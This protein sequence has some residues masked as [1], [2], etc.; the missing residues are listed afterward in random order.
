MEW[1]IPCNIKFYDIIGA[2]EKF[3]RIDWKQSTNIEIGDVV[4]IY[5]GNPI[6][7]IKYKCIAKKVDLNNAEIDDSEF[8]VDGEVYEDYGRYMELE[9]VEAYG[10]TELSYN[11]LKQNGLNSVQGPSKVSNKLSDYIKSVTE[12]NDQEG[13]KLI[14][15]EKAGFLN[16]KAK[17][18]QKEIA[19]GLEEEKQLEKLRK[20]F[21]DHFI[22]KRIAE[23]KKE[24]YVVG[25]GRQDT[26][27]YRLENELR[28]LGDI[29]GST[30][31][32]FGLYY[33][34]K[35][36]DKENKYRVTEGKFG[37]DL[38]AAFERIKEQIENLIIAGANKNYAEIRKCLLS[39]MF[40][41]KI[42]STYFP[43]EYLS[44]FSDEHLTYFLNKL[45]VAFTDGED[46]LDKQLKLV[47]WKKDNSIAFNWSMYSFSRFLYNAFGKPKEAKSELKDKLNEYD[48][49]YPKEHVVNLG[50][51]IN[52]WIDLLKDSEVFFEK[53]VD[54][55][56]RIYTGEYHAKTCY[57]L[58]QEDGVSPS[59]YIK[60][61]VALARRIADKIE[62]GKIFRSNGKEMWWGIPFWGKYREDG[63]FEWK[64]RPKLAKAMQNIYPE[65]DYIENDE[66]AENEFL[67]TLRKQP[68]D[69]VEPFKEY[70]GIP[71]DKQEAMVANGRLF[72]PRD[73]RIAINALDKAKYKCEID[74]NHPL[75]K[76]KNSDKNYTEPHHL[77]PMCFSDKFDVSLDVEENIVSLCSNCHNQVHYGSGFEILIERLYKERVDA[78]KKAGIDITLDQLLEMYK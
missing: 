72:Y 21:V 63:H 64:L 14:R 55:I 13:E 70:K 29:H 45:G 25:L 44:I 69:E 67:G 7:A 74:D 35:G 1:I 65:L 11:V 33:G 61:V 22:I 16:H 39:P 28:E 78:L 54:L 12:T 68:I 3:D 38:D 50:I 4:Y 19:E 62:I 34:T 30:A 49:N 66:I 31:A 52:Q 27:C 26:F 73:R 41:G 6:S 60:P 17:E 77:V 47:S 8:I 5:I 42:L 40:K 9:L 51:T 10:D 43:E 20:E 71:K 76:R 18:F 53:D 46:E 32:K 75:F 24:E 56:K 23:M 58:G 2:F 57:E 48:K 59:T 36:E 37:S 15:N